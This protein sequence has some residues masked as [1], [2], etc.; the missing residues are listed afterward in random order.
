MGEFMEGLFVGVIITAAAFAI[1][2]FWWG[3][4]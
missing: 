4:W 1:G 3:V 2:L